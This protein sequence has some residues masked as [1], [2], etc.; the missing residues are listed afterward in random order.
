MAVKQVL[1]VSWWHES[2]V[3]WKL[4]NP[5]LNQGDCA[6]HFNVSESYMSILCNS[7]AFRAYEAGRRAEHNKAVSKDI[8]EQVEEVASVSLEV[9]HERIDKER[10]SIGL[11][12]V[13]ETCEMALKSLGFGVKPASG[14]PVNNVLVLN[15]ATPEALESA[16]GKMRL[17]NQSSPEVGAG[18]ATEASKQGELY[19]ERSSQTLPA[20]S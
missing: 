3:D 8:I 17:I 20:P 16:R 11:K 4:K 1:K 5:E 13:G 12:I 2:V 6:R 9:L 14:Q 15:A 7:D 19:E 18:E 10:D